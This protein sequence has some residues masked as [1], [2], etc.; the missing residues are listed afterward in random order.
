MTYELK[1]ED[2][3]IEKFHKMEKKDKKQLERINKK[4][5]E[6]REN[7][8]RFKPLG[9][10]MKG[11]RRVHVGHFVLVF[12]IDEINKIVKLTDYD[13]HDNIYRKQN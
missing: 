9:N 5:L 11:R 7:P 6:I 2:K 1:L 10:K 12:S 13:H 4:I 8:D 3:L